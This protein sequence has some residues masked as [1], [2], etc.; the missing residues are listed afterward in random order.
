MKKVDLWFL[1]IDKFRCQRATLEKFITKNSDATKKGKSFPKMFSKYLMCGFSFCWLFLLQFLALFF[2]LF[3]KIWRVCLAAWKCRRFCFVFYLH[4]LALFSLPLFCFFFF[5]AFLFWIGE[6]WGGK[7]YAIK[8]KRR[9]EP[10]D[11]LTASFENVGQ[12][13]TKSDKASNH[14][15][16]R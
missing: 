7:T 16:D 12:V 8:I 3:F 2:V 11:W 10:F 14:C 15:S 6:K 9:F 4:C 5:Y 1:F 13:S